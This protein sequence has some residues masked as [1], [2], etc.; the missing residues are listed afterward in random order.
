MED[1]Q[2]YREVVIR[3]LDVATKVKDAMTKESKKSVRGRHHNTVKRT[4]ENKMTFLS[5]T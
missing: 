4:C 3:S 2:I 1:T 5:F